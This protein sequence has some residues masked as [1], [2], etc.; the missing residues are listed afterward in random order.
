MVALFCRVHK[1]FRAPYKQIKYTYLAL[2]KEKDKPGKKE[3]GTTSTFL[4]WYPVVIGFLV[5]I[6]SGP[7]G[8]NGW[9]NV[10]QAS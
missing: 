2:Q 10:W 5:H 8:V 4:I 3:A 7:K 6:L 1:A 9:P